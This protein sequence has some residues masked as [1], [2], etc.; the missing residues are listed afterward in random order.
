MTETGRTSTTDW[1]HEYLGEIERLG[2]SSEYESLYL[3]PRTPLTPDHQEVIARRVGVDDF[4]VD[5]PRSRPALIIGKLRELVADERSGVDAR[6]RLLDI[7]CG[8][9]V[10]LWQI[11]QSFPDA[12]CVGVDCNKGLFT[13]NAQAVDAGVILYK[14]Y[15]QHLFTRSPGEDRRFDVTL[16][17]NTYRG[18]QSADL[19]EAEKDLPQQADGWFAT[20]ARYTIVTATPDQIKRLRREGWWVEELGKG[21]DDSTMIC[22][23]R[24]QRGPWLAYTAARVRALV[25]R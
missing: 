4:Q 6:F 9:S 7:A 17:L 15:L 25:A 16:M 3:W 1:T 23:S 10:V 24:V 12:T 5:D 13:T 2:E 8:D 21:E 14:G 20:N 22:M 19:R 11:K 18:W